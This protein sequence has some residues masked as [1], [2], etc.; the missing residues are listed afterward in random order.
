MSSWRQPLTVRRWIMRSS[1]L[2]LPPTWPPRYSACGLMPIIQEHPR[3]PG[4]PS[5]TYNS[6]SRNTPDVFRTTSATCAPRCGRS[7][8][9]TQTANYTLAGAK[10]RRRRSVGNL[11]A[12]ELVDGCW[13]SSNL[14]IE[15]T[16]SSVRATSHGGL[17]LPPGRIFFSRRWEV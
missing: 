16:I 2:C 9:G 8:A 12:K 6:P 14:P 15:S 4:S 11:Q 7:T 3:A 1:S 17:A 13:D 5:P 10:S